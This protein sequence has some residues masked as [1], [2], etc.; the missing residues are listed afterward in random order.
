MSVAIAPRPSRTRRLDYALSQPVAADLAVCL[1]VALVLCVLAFVG[2]GGTTLD[3]NTF[4]QILLVAGGCGLGAGALAVPHRRARVAPLYGGR[5]LGLFGVLALLT[6]LSIAWSLDPESSWLEANRTLSYLAAFGGTLAFVRV[7]PT[8]WNAVL[9]G[10]ALASVIVCAWALLTKVFPDV[11]AEGEL[12]GRLRAPFD[13]WNA[14]GLM[15]AMG[16]PPL[17]WLGARRSGHASLNALAFPGLGILLTTIMLAYS[18][19]ALLALAIGLAAWFT[20]V[21]LRLRGAVT[22]LIP[23]V[24]TAL[25]VAW[26][27]GQ[28]DL[29]ANYID[30]EQRADAGHQLGVLLALQFVLLTAAGLG[31]GFWSATR[32][33]AERTRQ[34]AGR[35]L[36][37]SLIAAFFISVTA[38]AVKPGGLSGQFKQLT[39]P[40]AATPANTPGRLTAASSV[41]ARY[42]D[43]A[44]KVHADNPWLGTGAGS[45]GT[46]RQF[47]RKQTI[48]VQHAHGYVVQTLSDLGWFGLFASL[49]A[50][51]AWLAAAFGVVGTGRADRAVAWDAERVGVATLA[52]VVLVFGVHSAIDWTWFIPANAVLAIICAGWVAGRP[53]LRIRLAAEGPTGGVAAARRVGVLPRGPRFSLRDRLVAWQP[54]PYRGAWA[55]GILAVG[56]AVI[57]SIVQPLRSQNALDAASHRLDAGQYAQAQSIA[58]TAHDRDPLSVEPWFLLASTR[59]YAGDRKGA[60]D[61]LVQAIKTQPANSE[62]WRR[63]GDYELFVLN[64]PQGALRAYQAAYYLDPQAP[65]AQSDVLEASRATE[66]ITP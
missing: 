12:L 65:G 48:E 51:A 63:L 2:K 47:Y 17:V 19:G 54:S 43:E 42:W 10:V 52:T 46:A 55:I 36:I 9:G 23:M 22:L 16:V 20:F 38:I 35:I 1:G 59:A 8:R 14:I 53:P 5:T 15:A 56:I 66:T 32:E 3:A 58:T 62:A 29:T 37:G 6:A 45:Y 50:L 60:I 7:V 21:P 34:L 13:Y 64:D 4:A 49:A 24:L 11:L 31:V 44:L 40:N 27:F 28:H 33:P 18:R 61:A 57:W 30:P 41:R 39:D 25:V 26:A